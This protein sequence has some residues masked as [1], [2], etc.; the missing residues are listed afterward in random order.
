MFLED[1]YMKYIGGSAC[2]ELGKSYR[3]LRFDTTDKYVMVCI[4]ENMCCWEHKRFF[5]KDVK[6]ERKLKL[7]RINES[8]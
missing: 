2:L 5:V 4:N 1:C 3:I 6:K 8:W 7:K